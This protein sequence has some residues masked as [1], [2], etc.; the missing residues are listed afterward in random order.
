MKIKLRQLKIKIKSMSMEQR[1]IKHETVKALATDKWNWKQDH[2]DGANHDFGRF[3]SGFG[4]LRF[5]RLFN[6]RP[7]IR[8]ANIAYGLLR[9]RTLEQLETPRTEKSLAR[10]PY[11][12][13][14]WPRIETIMKKFGDGTVTFAQIKQTL[15]PET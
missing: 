13:P 7:E 14:D 2:K 11:R 8:S 5:H 1:I 4:S 3:D 12:E 6:V 9:G 10:K 15:C